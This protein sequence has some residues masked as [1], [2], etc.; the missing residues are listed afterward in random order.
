MLGVGNVHEAAA[1]NCDVKRSLSKKSSIG[2]ILTNSE[3]GSSGGGGNSGW[4]GGG[5]VNQKL[6][7]Y[8]RDNSVTNE[9]N[10]GGGGVGGVGRPRGS[11]GTS[12]TLMVERKSS[13]NLTTTNGGPNSQ[14]F[15]QNQNFSAQVQLL[16]CSGGNFNNN[17]TIDARTATATDE[18]CSI[19]ESA[20]ADDFL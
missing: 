1:L 2:I 13:S 18:N 19:T 16:T 17:T 5:D 3:N 7:R 10:S 9:S 11:S 4:F 20:T 15:W 12:C 6:W 14:E 8:R